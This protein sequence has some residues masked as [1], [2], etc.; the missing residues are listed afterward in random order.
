MDSTAATCRAFNRSVNMTPG[1]IRAWAKDRRS[2]EASEPETRR[3]LPALASLKA[4][5]CA[6]WSKRDVDAAKR[7]LS[8]NARMGGLVR[9]KGCKRVAVLSL[10]N[11]GRQPPQCA[12]PGVK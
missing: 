10:R 8:F 9:V 5:P 12:V 7:V 4:K 6:R 11:W 1:E 2:L 3:R